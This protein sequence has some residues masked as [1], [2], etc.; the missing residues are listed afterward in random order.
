MAPPTQQSGS[1]DVKSVMISSAPLDLPEHRD[2]VKD[3]CLR[4]G[5]FPARMNILCL[6][7]SH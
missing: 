6:A 5:M 4:Q 1:T 7:L 3:A 2:P